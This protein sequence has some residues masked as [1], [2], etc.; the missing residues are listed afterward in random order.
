MSSF[1]RGIAF[2][3]VFALVVVSAFAVPSEEEAI[4]AWAIA[5]LAYTA[6]AAQA[7]TGMVPGLT[8]G[9]TAAG[10]TYTFEDF[11]LTTLEIDPVVD[12]LLLGNRYETVSGRLVV[13]ALGTMSGEYELT[14]G[15]VEELSFE[16]DGVTVEIT[17][18]GASYTY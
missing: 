4:E 11:D 13:D 5:N 12:M 15:P 10:M 7:A 9:V 6:S 1:R 2:L 18:D 17:A 3:V 16:S 14:G 8:F